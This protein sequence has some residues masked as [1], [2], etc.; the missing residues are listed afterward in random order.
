M[1][2][3][4]AGLNIIYTYHIKSYLHFYFCIFMNDIN[5]NSI[6]IIF[7]FNKILLILANRICMNKAYKAKLHNSYLECSVV[8][9][10]C[11]ADPQTFPLI[12]QRLYLIN[13]SIFQKYIK[14]N[15]Q[16]WGC[17]NTMKKSSS[18]SQ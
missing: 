6:T 17:F 5:N 10:L 1:L 3:C 4:H 2:L 14:K 11:F 12:Y 16:Y 13:D 7:F 18:Q 9:Q 15:I 8:M